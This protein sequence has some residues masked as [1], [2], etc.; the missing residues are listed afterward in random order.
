MR[1]ALGITLEE[2]KQVQVELQRQQQLMLSEQQRMEQQRGDTSKS[3]STQ[4]QS[5]NAET[6][7][8]IT[9]A[10]A[11]ELERLQAAKSFRTRALVFTLV[12][13]GVSI[14]AI[15]LMISRKNKR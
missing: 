3:I 11:T 9:A 14:G 15:L 4:G 6:A 10:Q 2:A 1:T 12:G 5:I 13:S 7:I 8:Q